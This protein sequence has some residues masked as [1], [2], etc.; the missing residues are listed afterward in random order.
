MI[1]F[2]HC[3]LFLCSTVPKSYV[4]IEAF[5]MSGMSVKRA[6]PLYCLIGNNDWPFIIS[7]FASCAV[8]YIFCHCAAV[9]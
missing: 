2:R 5:S 8:G 6:T 1:G 4:G 9:K 3:F 7:C